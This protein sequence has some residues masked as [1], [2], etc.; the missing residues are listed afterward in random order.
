MNKVRAVSAHTTNPN[1][2]ESDNQPR[3]W[4]TVTDSEGKEHQ[5][6]ASDPMDAIDML[7]QRL[8]STVS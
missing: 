1:T 2:P 3:V 6:Y 4:H 5:V 7:N 8:R